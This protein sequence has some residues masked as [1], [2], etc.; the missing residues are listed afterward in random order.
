MMRKPVIG[1]FLKDHNKVKT[2][3]P[4]VD[5]FIGSIYDLQEL[6][7]DE[8]ID[9]F[10]YQAREAIDEVMA[11][12]RVKFKNN[13]EE[14]VLYGKIERPEW[15]RYFMDI[16]KA[17]AA[18]AI[19]PSIH[20]GCVIIDTDRRILATGYNG[21]PPGFPDDS[22]PRTRPEKYPYTIHAEANAIASSRAD[23]RL[24]TLYCTHSPCI[25]CA[26]LIIT[27]GIQRVIYETEY[28]TSAAA[29]DQSALAKKLFE[30]GRVKLE[31]LGY[32]DP[33]L[34]EKGGMDECL[35]TLKGGG[36]G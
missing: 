16:S 33:H 18:R 10:G 6:T 24:G 27:A 7:E 23:L 20:V 19:D 26:K 15:D 14:P 8:F 11:Q 1:L 5:E 9:L 21:F 35:T 32:V 13:R 28:A 31:Q 17:V 12:Y 29:M 25:E 36:D 34:I 3:I 22:L 2:N 30:M 4:Y